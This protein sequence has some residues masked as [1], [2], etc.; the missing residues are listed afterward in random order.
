MN[1][2]RCTYIIQPFCLHWCLDISH[3][4][5]C[6]QFWIHFSF[7]K[8]LFCIQ[9]PRLDDLDLGFIK[10]IAISKV[11]YVV[12]WLFHFGLL[13]FLTIASPTLFCSLSRKLD[14]K[15]HFHFFTLLTYRT[16]KVF[17]CK[18]F[19]LTLKAE[20]K[21]DKQYWQWNNHYYSKQA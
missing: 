2:T 8:Y 9:R 5:Q 16:G 3:C 18:C 6:I 21:F 11:V 10:V 1:R 15:N 4:M 12:Y 17:S 19:I 14:P 7:K 13:H 20:K